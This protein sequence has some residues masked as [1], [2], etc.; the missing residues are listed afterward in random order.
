MNL[1][2]SLSCYRAI[3]YSLLLLLILKEA[4]CLTTMSVCS[5]AK[6]YIDKLAWI[7]VRNRKQLVARSCGKVAF[8]TPGGKREGDS[9]TDEDALCREIKEECNVKLIPSTIHLYGVFEAQAY[10][11]PPGTMVRITGYTADYDN[12]SE[13]LQPS[14]EIE[15]LKW[16]S[17][18]FSYDKLTETG[19]MILEDLKEKDLVD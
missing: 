18:S 2:F 6:T 11:K 9:E 14:S 17:S 13:E 3:Y 7:C 19:I 8:F 5:S 16:I 4:N 1:N 12:N 10:G 15:E